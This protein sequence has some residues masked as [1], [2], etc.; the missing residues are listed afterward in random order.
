MEA[1]PIRTDCFTEKNNKKVWWKRKDSLRQ[2]YNSKK[3]SL[4]LVDLDQGLSGIKWK[5]F[6]TQHQSDP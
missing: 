6:V 4:W 5:K 2:K 3:G 1:C